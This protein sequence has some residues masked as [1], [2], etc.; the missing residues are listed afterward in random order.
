MAYLSRDPLAEDRGFTLI[1][2]LV[3][4]FIIGV[5]AAIAIPS[6]LSQQSKSY[7]AV[8]K[9]VARNGETAAE[10]Y[11]TEHEGK[12]DSLNVEAV[13]QDDPTIQTAAGGKNAYLSVAESKESGRGYV[14][15]AI[16]A[17]SG[18]SFTVTRKENGEVLRT[19]T[20]GSSDEAG[21]KTGTW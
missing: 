5:L 17:Q 6:L 18:D 21:C 19:C 8:A 12:Y 14:L 20:R 3:V 2:I 10:T 4:V 15:T 13:H 7:D 9:E 1:E 16:A 11:A